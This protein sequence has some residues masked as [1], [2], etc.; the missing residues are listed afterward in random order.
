MSSEEIDEKTTV[1]SSTPSKSGKRIP[2]D[3]SEFIA[4]TVKNENAELDG[5]FE[6]NEFDKT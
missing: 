1:T 2:K 5:Q 3:F 6:E 4:M